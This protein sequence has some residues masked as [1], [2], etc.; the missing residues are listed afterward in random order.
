QPGGIAPTPGPGRPD[1]WRRAGGCVHSGLSPARLADPCGAR[2]TDRP[3][4]RP[5]RRYRPQVR[6]RKKVRPMAQQILIDP[7]TRIE[8]HA[9]ITIQLDDAGKVSDARFHVA[10]FRGFEK[11]CEGR[12]LWEMPG[13]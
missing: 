8:G 7:V 5:A 1:P 13:I 6:L 3:A 2:A 9:K 4:S 11:F 12:P 10:V